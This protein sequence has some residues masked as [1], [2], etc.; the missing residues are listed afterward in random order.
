MN[1]IMGAIAGVLVFV[2]IVGGGHALVNREKAVVTEVTSQ[3]VKEEVVAND[4]AAV[5]PAEAAKVDT[6]V[7]VAKAGS[8]EAYAPTKLA[9]AEKGDVVLFFFA[10]WCPSCRGLAADIEKNLAAIPRDLTILKVEYDKEF[11]LRKKY[12]V[13][14]QHTLV[15]VNAKG[16]LIKKWSGS[17]T[18]ARLVAEVQ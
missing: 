1:K 12:G 13:T 18:L 9:L 5:Q 3:E 11:E 6:N 16:D 14:Y 15:Q 8:Y 2:A 17:P 7:V 4:T 10:S